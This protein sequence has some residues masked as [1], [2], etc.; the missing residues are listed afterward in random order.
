MDATI[1]TEIGDFTLYGVKS[2]YQCSYNKVCIKLVKNS[3]SSEI[4]LDKVNKI[5]NTLGIK[6]EVRDGKLYIESTEHNLVEIICKSKFKAPWKSF[7]DNLNDLKEFVKKNK[8]LPS[9]KDKLWI[10]MNRRKDNPEVAEIINKY[11]RK[12]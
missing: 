12:S 8:E 5:L 6:S 11:L 10:F 9:D 4:D 7:E 2:V 1:K 3:K